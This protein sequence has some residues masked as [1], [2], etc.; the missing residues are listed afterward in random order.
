MLLRD[1]KVDL[2]I[3][4]NMHAFFFTKDLKINLHFAKRQW[5]FVLR[6]AN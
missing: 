6:L 2:V 4:N 3:A 5:L 1:G